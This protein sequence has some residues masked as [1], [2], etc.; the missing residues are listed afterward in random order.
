MLLKQN[1]A[2]IK[3]EKQNKEL[4]LKDM[5]KDKEYIVSITLFI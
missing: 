4:P 1:D 3:L 2:Y 5:K